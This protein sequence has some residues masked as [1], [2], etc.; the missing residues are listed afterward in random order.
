MGI[1]L[2]VPEE[3]GVDQAIRH[4]RRAS[5]DHRLVTAWRQGVNRSGDQLLADAAVAQD[6]HVLGA[7]G[8]QP[9]L[10]ADAPGQRRLADEAVQVGFAVADDVA[11]WKRRCRGH[12]PRALSD[13]QDQSR[14]Q[15][16]H[17]A[18]PDHRVGLLGPVDHHPA[19]ADVLDLEQP[20]W[21]GLYQQLAARDRAVG[22]GAGLV[23]V[24]GTLADEDTW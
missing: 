1:V 18:M 21:L 2:G 8:Q 20:A 22:Q 24:A 19:A 17:V 12:D 5:R 16:D 7:R 10:F 4:G 9:H 14:W 13:H 3:L 6:Q 15:R 11:L 23:V